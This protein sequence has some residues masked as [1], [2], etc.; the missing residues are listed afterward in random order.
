MERKVETNPEK[1]GLRDIAKGTI[2]FSIKAEDTLENLQVHCAFKNFC[3]VETDNNYTLGIRKLLEYYEAD[4]KVN[5]IFTML[6]DQSVALQ[7]LAS[8]VVEMQKPKVSK[9]EEEESED[10]G[11]F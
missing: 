11:S 8:S 10:D 2:R 7:D 1:D 3:Q 5:T 6:Q 9:E 4:A